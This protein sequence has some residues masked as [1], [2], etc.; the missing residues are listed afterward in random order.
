MS[1][2]YLIC[3]GQEPCE[4]NSNIRKEIYKHYWKVIN[5]ADG[6]IDPRYLAIKVQRANGGEWAIQHR[7]EVMPVCVLTQLRTLYVS[8]P[9]GETIYGSYVALD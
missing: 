3:S 6:W 5:N 8:K 9:K 1:F 4:D 2:R 7:R